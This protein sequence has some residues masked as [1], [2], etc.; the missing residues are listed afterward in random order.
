VGCELGCVFNLVLT[1]GKLSSGEFFKII[2]PKTIGSPLTSFPLRSEK[3]NK[4]IIKEAKYEGSFPGIGDCP[5]PERPE[6]AF[7]GR[8]NVGKS[9]LINMLCERKDLAHVSKKPGKTQALNFYLINKSW[10][11]VDLPGYGYA[12]TAQKKRKTWGK[13]IADYLLERS[14]LQCAFVLLDANVPPQELDIEFINWLGENQVPFVLVYTKTD[15]LKSLQQ[16]E[17]IELI[18]QSLLQSWNELPQEFITSSIRRTGRE[19]VLGLIEK[20][21]RA[22]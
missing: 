2:L 22:G 1:L 18:R 9:S 16:A 11:L 7:I 10:Y 8:S 14:S 21:N 6:Y 3:K 17:N 4:M 13:M 5:K 15:K 19:E 12:K 20:V